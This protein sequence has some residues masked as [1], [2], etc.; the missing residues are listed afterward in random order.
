M[1][2]EI[3]KTG[4]YFDTDSEGYLINPASMT[5]IQEEWKPIVNDVVKT[6]KE[7]F[8][9]DLISVYLR[10]SVSKGEA[11]AGISD[12]DSFAYQIHCDFALDLIT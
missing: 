1:N 11:V 3:R 4:S 6:Y 12:I 7:Q 10:G 5:K 8:G 9:D 2:I